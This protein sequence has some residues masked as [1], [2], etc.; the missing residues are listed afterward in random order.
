MF[1]GKYKS[2]LEERLLGSDFVFSALTA[3]R[4]RSWPETLPSKFYDGEFCSLH[5]GYMSLFTIA[6]NL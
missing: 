4:S 2:N 1:S 6:L 5:V 3:Q